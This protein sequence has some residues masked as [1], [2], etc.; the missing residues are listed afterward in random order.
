MN[1]QRYILSVVFVLIGLAFIIKL[2]YIQVADPS[3][4]LSAN[5]NAFRHVTQHPARGMIFD[6][7]GKLLV[8]NQASYDLKAVYKDIKPFDTTELCHLLETDKKNI[9]KQLNEAKQRPYLP[10][11]ISKQISKSGYAK[12]QEALY[13]F[14]GFYVETRTL[15]KYMLPLAAHLLGY[16]GEVNRNH[17]KKEP[18]YR[19]GDYIGISG[20]EKSYEQHLRGQK[21]VKILIVDVHNRE[22]G[23]YKGGMYDTAAVVGRNI[24]TTLDADLQELGE[25]LMQNK[26][27]SVVA[28]E[29]ATGEILALVSAPGYDPNLLIGK[30]RSKNYRMLAN[31]KLKPLFN[32]AL[33]AQYPPGSTLKPTSALIGLHEG[34]IFPNTVFV[35]SGGYSTGS[36]IVKDHISGAVNFVMSIQHSSNVYYCQVFKHTLTDRKYGSISGAYQ[37]W[38][39]HLH[40]FGLGIK[41]GTDLAYEKKGLVYPASYFDRLYGVGKWNHNTVISLSIGQGELGFTP[42]QIANMTATIANRG[43]YITPHIVRKITGENI[44]PEYSIRHYT[45]IDKA[46][47]P[48]VIEGM[49]AVVLAGTARSAHIEGVEVCGKTGTAQ[50]PHGKDH[51]IFVAFAPRENPKIAIA[52]YVE[53]A[54]Y[55]ST[56]AAPIASLM[57]EK[58]LTD[59]ISRDYVLKRITDANLIEKM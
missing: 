50:N 57:I 47:F 32:R 28:I 14:P 48:P 8:F 23:S 4:K 54:G 6:R 22:K 37:N 33:K 42:L 59:S 53:N 39:Q 9:I 44:D 2:F 58:Y 24:T 36:H 19:S 12:L 21:G 56:W 31:D 27:G 10:A 51:S 41:L 25:T 45:A 7:N 11:V 18:Y 55:G 1:F 46:L 16:V 20:I 5:N 15:R 3:Y 29:P 38:K 40:S 35:S 13:K 17:I 30:Q 26:L 49:R 43:Y 34:V 52:V